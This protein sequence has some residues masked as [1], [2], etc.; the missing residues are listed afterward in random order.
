MSTTTHKI[1]FTRKNNENATS[2]LDPVAP[3]AGQVDLDA[4]GTFC[5][6]SDFDM[7]VTAKL[8]EVRDIELPVWLSAD[9]WC[10]SYI[11]WR[12]VWGAGVDKSWPE[13][14]QRGLARLSFAERF[15]ACKLLSVKK[16]R[17]T[18]R[19]S[20][21]NQFVAWLESAPEARK[22]ANPLSSKQW[23]AIERPHYESERAES[24]IYRNRHI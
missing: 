19:A 1:L 11:S 15:A 7:L 3:W 6:S 16:F 13:S 20:L 21:R 2:A 4:T 22:F 8:Y 10:G 18:F 23:A 24:A 14:W 5:A 17:S 12:Y 9:E